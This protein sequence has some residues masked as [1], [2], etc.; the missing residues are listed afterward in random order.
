MELLVNS[1]EI[2]LLLFMERHLE[3]LMD[4]K[5]EAATDTW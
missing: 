2:E 5:K 3:D 4:R 1:F